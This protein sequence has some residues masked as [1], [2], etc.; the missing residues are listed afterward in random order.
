MKRFIKYGAIGVLAACA[1]AVAER[2]HLT[3]VQADT[4]F[5]GF[6][7]G[8]L[9]VSRTVYQGT[10]STV[11]V[12]QLLPPLCITVC[13]NAIADGTYPTVFNNTTV[14]GNFGVTSTIY[15]D[16]MTTGGV[17][18]QT[19]ALDPSRIATSFS[20]KSELGLNLSTDG[21]ALT[22]M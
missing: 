12:G 15:L 4:P 17:V 13:T 6:T 7:A 16:E 2:R 11:S 8:D 14:D 21:T 20:S 1:F 22:L 18:L 3:T 5:Q 10:P 19:L 9:I